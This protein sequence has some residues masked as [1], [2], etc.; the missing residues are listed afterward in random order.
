[1]TATHADRIKI[2]TPA[3]LIEAIPYLL[4]FHP[5]DSLVL[6]G[7]AHPSDRRTPRRVEVVLRIDLPQDPI[8]ADDLHSLI[9]ALARSEVTS[10]VSVLF[11]PTLKP[12]GSRREDFAGIAELLD[13]CLDTAGME[14]LDVL[15]AG[16]SRWRSLICADPACCPPEGRA[17]ARG[18]SQAAAQA[19]VAGLVALADRTEL[20]AQFDGLSSD[21]RHELD[22]R[23][24]AAENRITSAVLSNGLRRLRRT[25]TAALFRAARQLADRADCDFDGHSLGAQAFEP[26]GPRAS[27]P[28]ASGG[29]TGR[30]VARFGVALTDLTIRDELWLVIDERSIDAT[31]L[32]REL[33][34]QLPA[35]YDAAPL[36]LYGWHQWRDGNGSLAC[37]AAE[38]AL[39]SD[40]GYTAAS[41]LLCAAQNGLNPTTTPSLRDGS[42]FS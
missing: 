12:S 11:T 35:P 25:D 22:N 34:T 28:A 7:F 10:V 1:M 31:A 17:R 23:L 18:Y 5:S 9:A 32:L 30:Q 8:S 4:G 29:L 13:G 19:T 27:R 40:R 15:L 42:D 38:R 16:D 2:S 33:L 21:R 36:F 24:A 39:A 20:A 14:L 26:S 41:L 6:V 37:I 3:E